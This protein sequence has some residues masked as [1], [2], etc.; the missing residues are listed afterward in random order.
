VMYDPNVALP[1]MS[2]VNQP[3]TH[4]QH[5]MVTGTSVVALR[6]KDG[7][8]VAADTLGSYG[9]TAMFKSIQRIVPIG[10]FTMI[11]GGG[12]YSDFQ[13]IHQTLDDYVTE[14]REHDDG[15]RMYPHEI[16]SYL[17]QM[18]YARRNKMD[19][20]YNQLVVAGFRDG[21]SF[22]GWV[23]KLGTNFED[24]HLATGYGAH[25][26][27]PLLR[28]HYRPDLSCDE[29]V[30]VVEMCMRVLFYRDKNT[31]N[32]IQ[33]ATVSAAG[34][35]IHPPRELATEWTNME[36]AENKRVQKLVQIFVPPAK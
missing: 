4:T 9:S 6:Y 27:I 30:A 15:S 14:E 35:S 12:E 18:M 20:L 25:I 32:K 13:Y 19:P 33:F 29:A 10:E 8:V 7:V 23:D 1:T 17:G 2:V 3:I 16:F 22:L 31:I 26:A 28:K 34:I 11:G 21:K 5:P 24:N 36:Q